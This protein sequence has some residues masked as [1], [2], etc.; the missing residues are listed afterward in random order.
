MTLT[1]LLMTLLP[2]I[3]F[4][5]ADATAGLKTGVVLAI[6][7]SIALCVA[8]WLILGAFEPISLIEPVFLLCSDSFRCESKTAFTLSF[9]LWWS[10]SSAPYS[11]RDSR[12]QA[13]LFWFVGHP[14]WTSSCH[15]KNRAYSPAQ[16]FLKSCRSFRMHSSTSFD[17]RSMGCLGCSQKK[18]LGLGRC[19]TRRIPAASRNCRACHAALVNQIKRTKSKRS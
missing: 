2:I 1:F 9:S 12:S 7:L 18:Q 13:N 6:V 5:I 3:A 15:L 4:A 8:N 11:W 19:P 10:M 14:Q 17:S 16:P